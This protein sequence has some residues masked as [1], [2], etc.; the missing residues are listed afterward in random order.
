[1]C[2]SECATAPSQ[3]RVALQIL[4]IVLAVASFIWAFHRLQRV[5]LVL[6]LATFFAYVTAPLVELAEHPIRIAGRPRRL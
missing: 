6:I 2:P 1:V 5:V 4:L 3:K